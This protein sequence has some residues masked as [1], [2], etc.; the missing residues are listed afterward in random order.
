MQ[1]ITVVGFDDHN[2]DLRD[3][4][5]LGGLCNAGTN[6]YGKTP[7]RSPSQCSRGAAGL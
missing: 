2:Q 5:D 1:S 4:T 3:L 7:Y 6:C